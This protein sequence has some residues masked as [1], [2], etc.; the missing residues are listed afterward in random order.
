MFSAPVDIHGCISF[1]ITAIIKIATNDFHLWSSV[2]CYQFLPLC[3]KRSLQSNHICKFLKFG[4]VYDLFRV[5]I[6][7]SLLNLAVYA[8][9]CNLDSQITSTTEDVQAPTH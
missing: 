9:C 3:D 4:C 5:I 2:C 1:D 8:I 6:L 7:A